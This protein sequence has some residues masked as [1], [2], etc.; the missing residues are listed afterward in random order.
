MSW[1]RVACI[2]FV[3]GLVCVTAPGSQASQTNISVS[4]SSG[5]LSLTSDNYAAGFSTNSPLN[6]SFGS[7]AWN[8]S[9]YS[10]TNGSLSFDWGGNTFTD[11]PV[12]GA[13]SQ[14]TYSSGYPVYETFYY[15]Y[16]CGWWVCWGSYTAQV[17]Y[18]SYGNSSDTVNG[19]FAAGTPIEIGGQPF[20][21]SS[22]S[23]DF[24]YGNSYQSGYYGS[25]NNNYFYGGS[26][27]LTATPDAV[28]PEPSTWFT[29][30]TGLLLLGFLFRRKILH[31]PG[32]GAQAPQLMANA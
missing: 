12:S 13:T 18:V 14:S 32:R 9:G 7:V 26:I 25:Y 5:S 16:G 20:E 11:L 15:S 24:S 6:L 8:G 17:G 1:T 23:F 21:I 28:A 22:G 30:G 10:D 31:D 27:N 29:M 2:L 19:T 4:F 3:V